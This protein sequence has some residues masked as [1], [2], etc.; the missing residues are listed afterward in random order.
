MDEFEVTNSF[1][2]GELNAMCS[3][4]E[5]AMRMETR[6]I[7][8]FEV[9][10]SKFVKKYQRSSADKKYLPVEIRTI[11][12]CEKSVEYLLSTILDFDVNPKPGFTPACYEAN[13]FDIYSF[14]R[15]RLRAVRVDLH[16]QNCVSDPEFI[17]IHEICLRFELLSLF[18][19]WGRDFGKDRKFDL[20]MSLTALSQTIDPL[21]KAWASTPPDSTRSGTASLILLLSLTSSSSKQFKSQYL[22]LECIANSIEIKNAFKICQ[23]YFAKNWAQFLT[24]FS[25]LDFLSSCALLPVIGRARRGLLR[26]MVRTNRPFFVRQGGNLPQARPETISLSALA[27]TLVTDVPGAAGIALFYGLQVR[28]DKVLL[29]PRQLSKNPFRW[30]MS[31]AEWNAKTGSVGPEFAWE[32]PDVFESR[33]GGGDAN[34][35]IAQ[36]VEPCLVDKFENIQ[37]T[38]KD[39]VVRKASRKLTVQPTFSAEGANHFVNSTLSVK[40]ST[41]PLFVPPLPVVVPQPVVRPVVPIAPLQPLPST[42]L[43]KR[44]GSPSKRDRESPSKELWPSLPSPKRKP[45]LPSI[46]SDFD[47]LADQLDTQL[48]VQPTLADKS[49]LDFL[50]K[51]EEERIEHERE[52][53]MAHLR[54]RFVALKC[55]RNWQAVWANRAKWRPRAPQRL[56]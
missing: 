36:S 32:R 17:R 48:V 10:Q 39:I 49:Q 53:N 42:P 34:D 23:A 24:E 55:F 16:V 44:G 43:V 25:K 14:L 8:K 29:P 46:Q 27:D 45:V 51:L 7:D 33:L 38:R 3:S 40:T 4:E 18:L 47:L 56:A 15:D 6:Q 37:T 2:T 35:E 1:L 26:T 12:A 30:W 31:S 50:E 28:G 20:H 21:T 19:L 9:D 54:T 41:I 11:D 52:M 13:F 22:K 5:I